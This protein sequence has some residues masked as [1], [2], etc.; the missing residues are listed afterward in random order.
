MGACPLDQ[1]KNNWSNQ[2]WNSSKRKVM[3][4]TAHQ[5][6]HPTF[7]HVSLKCVCRERER[8]RESLPVGGG[9]DRLS[10]EGNLW[11]AMKERTAHDCT[12]V[13]RGSLLE[14]AFSARV[15]AF[16][17]IATTIFDAST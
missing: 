12:I 17:S 2:K 4:S 9:G 7:P 6:I 8:E 3:N 15:I 11:S 16:R 1:T 14:G 13:T 10:T 5:A